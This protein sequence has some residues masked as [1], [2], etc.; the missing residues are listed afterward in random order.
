MGRCWLVLVGVLGGLYWIFRQ[1][2]RRAFSSAESR[3][4]SDGAGSLDGVSVIQQLRL[5]I[6]GI[7]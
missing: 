3:N 1:P 4:A 2:D 6:I 5:P 7:A